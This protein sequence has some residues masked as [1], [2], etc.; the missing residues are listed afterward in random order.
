MN[1]TNHIP[2]FILNFPSF[3]LGLPQTVT[4]AVTVPRIDQ[5]ITVTIWFLGP[6]ISLGHNW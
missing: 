5:I 1:G 4:V 3:G 2:A 6:K